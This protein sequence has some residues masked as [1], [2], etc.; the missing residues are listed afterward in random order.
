MSDKIPL[1][2]HSDS[3]AQPFKSCKVCDLDL[4]DG[5]TPYSIEKALKR[6]SEGEDLTL[7]ELA[8]CMNCA[9]KQAQKMSKESKEFIEKTMMTESFMTKRQE[10]WENDWNKNWNRSCIFSN[11]AVKINEEYHIV[12]HFIGNRVLPNQTPFL[13]GKEMID[14]VQENLS[15]ET[16]GEM[17]DFGRQFLGPDPRIAALLEDY[18][19]VFL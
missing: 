5:R 4:T 14:Y 15:E 8:I 10:I 7:F 3:E 17:D 12:G 16:K 13:I 6:T 19:L 2:F 11:Q 18:Q 9:E 1:A